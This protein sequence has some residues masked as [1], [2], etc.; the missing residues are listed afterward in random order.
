MNIAKDHSRIIITCTQRITPFLEME[1]REMGF[2]P[3]TVFKTGIELKG[4]LADCIRLNLGLRCGG[5][6]LYSLG[7]YLAPD[8]DAMYKHAK[9]VSWEKIIPA[10]G[11]FSITSFVR[12]DTITNQLFANVRLKDAIA[13]RF[14]ELTGSRPD[15]GPALSAVVI[16]LHWVGNEAEFFLDTSGETLMKHSYRKIPGKAPMLEALAAAC[17][18]ASKWDRRSPFINPMCGSGTL[19][20]EAALLATGRKPGLLRENYSFMHI[21]G[22]DHSVYMSELRRIRNEVVEVPGLHIGAT[23]ISDDAV[24]IS[25][26]NARMAGVEDLIDFRRCDFADTVVP[27]GGEGVVFFNPEYGD[28]LGVEKELQAVYR[29][30]G[31]FMKQSCKGYRGYVF[32]GNLELAK[33]VGLKAARRIEF[34]NGKIDC[35]L[36]EYELYQGSRGK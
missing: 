7:R 8:A 31:D 29:R 15:S 13:D 4:S 18:L 14:R 32:T 11:Y 23:D 34:F 1:V 20:I 16:N 17:I 10:D 25:R 6:V 28:R 24:N 21:C 22:Y 19:A 35:R 12:N 3:L 9:T 26:I 5:Q 30:M 27:E 33:Q 2:E 36:L